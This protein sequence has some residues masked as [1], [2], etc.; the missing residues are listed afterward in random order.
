MA[1]R[2]TTGQTRAFSAD[3]VFSYQGIKGA[4]VWSCPLT[5]AV[6]GLDGPIWNSDII[7]MSYCRL[8]LF[9]EECRLMVS[10]PCLSVLIT[11][12]HFVYFNESGRVYH[13]ASDYSTFLL[14]MF[15]HHHYQYGDLAKLWDRNDTSSIE[16]RVP[17]FQVVIDP[18]KVCSLVTFIVERKTTTWQPREMHI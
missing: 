9:C 3:T 7:V 13:A 8:S 14:L 5:S 6:C 15:C 1:S 2:R 16:C 17:T 18:W 10:A 4:K 12:K 11:L